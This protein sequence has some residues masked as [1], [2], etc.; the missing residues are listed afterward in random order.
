[1]CKFCWGVSLLS[2]GAV[3]AM[4]YM[5]MIRGSVE[6]SEGDGRTT[7]MLT[8]G[9]RELV[10]NEM[11][12]FLESVQEIVTGAVNKDMKSV[13]AAAHKSG[14][15]GVGEV[16]VSLMGKLPLAFKT[17]GMSTHKGFDALAMEAQDIGDPQVV[18]GK[19]G[20]LM[21]NCTTCHASYR[22]NIESV[23]GK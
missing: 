21:N 16:P 20:E 8:A 22:F 10:L 18:L 4:A 2:V 6:A 3:L 9:E 1:M 11:R 23:K 19:L 7:I 14:M 12:G 15:A 5:F 17:L 13:Y